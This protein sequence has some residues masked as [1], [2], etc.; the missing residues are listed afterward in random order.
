MADLPQE[1]HYGE[2]KLQAGSHRPR[3]GSAFRHRRDH[4]PHLAA[5]CDSDPYVDRRKLHDAGRFLQRDSDVHPEALA[6]CPERPVLHSGP[7]DHDP[8]QHIY[9]GHLSVAL[10]DDRVHIRAH[11]LEG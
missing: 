8:P 4:F 10:L 5:D 9:C 1:L 6:L 2:R 3:Q 7:Q 11:A